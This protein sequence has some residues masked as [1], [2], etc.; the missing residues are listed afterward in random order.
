MTTHSSAA[1]LRPPNTGDGWKG[2]VVKDFTWSK[3]SQ[4]AVLVCNPASIISKTKGAIEYTEFRPGVLPAYTVRS[5]GVVDPNTEVAMHFKPALTAA[6]EAAGLFVFV[7][8][9]IGPA[10]SCSA[11]PARPI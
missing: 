2:N 6:S 4:E 3:A 10:A 8:P 7:Y 1:L 9:S 11:A 5:T